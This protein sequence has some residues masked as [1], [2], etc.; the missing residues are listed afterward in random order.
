[1]DP[2]RALMEL[3]PI[4]AFLTTV[5]NSSPEKRYK[6]G[7]ASDK[8]KVEMPARV[9]RPQSFRVEPAQRAERNEGVG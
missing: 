4:P 1:M 8:P 2:S 6:A 7:K 3:M 5:G 9:S